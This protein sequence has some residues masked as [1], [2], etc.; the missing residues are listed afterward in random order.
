MI[1]SQQNV[2]VVEGLYSLQFSVLSIPESELQQLQRT[3][4]LNHV[5]L[6]LNCYALTAHALPLQYKNQYRM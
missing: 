3:L 6:W 1:G 5:T 2:S 4:W